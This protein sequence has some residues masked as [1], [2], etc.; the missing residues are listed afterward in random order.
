M[1]N[2]RL[3]LLL[4]AALVIPVAA[5]AQFARAPAAPLC[6]VEAQATPDR[7]PNFFRVVVRLRP[8]CPP[9][10]V[11]DVRLESYVGGTWP[12]KGWFRVTKT[13]P[14]IRSGIPW[15]WR[16]AWRRAD[17]HTDP[18]VIPGLRRTP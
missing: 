16:A 6:R 9:D 10:S 4:S 15:Y 8:D 18:L 7:L 14:L 3:T 11:A 12:R 1:S 17:G 13:K 2:K 5:L